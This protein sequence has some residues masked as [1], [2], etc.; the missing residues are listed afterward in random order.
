[1]KTLFSIL[2]IILFVN[3]ASAQND[4]SKLASADVNEQTIQLTWN[5]T[6]HDFTEVPVGHPVTA[7]FEFTNTGKEPIT[8]T[9]VKSSCGCTVAGYSK[10]PVLPGKTGEVSATYN[11]ARE[12]NFNKAVTVYMNSNQTQRLSVKGI[13]KKKEENI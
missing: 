8:I 11:A 12:G 10:E 9:K 6:V 3:L 13:V 5:S 1:M 7:T 4:Q 2:G